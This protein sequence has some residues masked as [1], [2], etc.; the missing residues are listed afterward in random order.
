MT[1]LLENAG[2][3]NNDDIQAL[4]VQAVANLDPLNDQHWT[5]DGRPSAAAV[6]LAIGDEKVNDAYVVWACPDARRGAAAPVQTLEPILEAAQETAPVQTVV[7]DILPTADEIADVAAQVAAA[8][9][10]LAQAQA[11]ALA[12][13]EKQD[14]LMEKVP[15]ET[16]TEQVQTY[17][18]RQKQLA[19]ERVSK[20]EFV[21]QNKG[22][23]ADLLRTKSPLDAAL[24]S[25]TRQR[26][27]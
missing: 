10:Q 14:A 20:I 12:L 23:L 7:I 24:A 26:P 6:A 13:R 9:A 8:N 17:L 5:E 15:V 21:K 16:H 18:Q 11:A 19:E 1:T 4:I 3:A 22:L 27:F 25:R 2:P